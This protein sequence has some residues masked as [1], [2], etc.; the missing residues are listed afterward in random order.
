MK[1][2]NIICR[3]LCKDCKYCN[4]HECTHENSGYCKH[5]ELWTPKWFD[6]D[7][8]TEKGGVE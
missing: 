2:H 8:P 4:G 6:N 7:N 5:C 3:Y 1:G